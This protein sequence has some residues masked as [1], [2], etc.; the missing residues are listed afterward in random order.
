LLA[1]SINNGVMTAYVS[2]MSFLV[3]DHARLNCE[4]ATPIHPLPPFQAWYFFRGQGGA[5]QASK[6]AAQ[7]AA[8]ASFQQQ[9]QQG[10]GR[11][12][13]VQ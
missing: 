13:V 6:K 5:E 8:L 1:T 4:S 11:A 7:E 3:D 10:G 9:Q 12:V 2:D